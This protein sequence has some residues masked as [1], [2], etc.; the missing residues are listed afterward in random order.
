M[1]IIQ[2]KLHT[3]L[4]NEMLMEIRAMAHQPGSGTTAP[5]ILAIMRGRMLLLHAMIVISMRK[6]MSIPSLVTL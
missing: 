5:R 2:K 3:L 6:K 4:K 1:K